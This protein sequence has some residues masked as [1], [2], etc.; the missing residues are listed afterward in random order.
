MQNQA[1]TIPNV[2]TSVSDNCPDLSQQNDEPKLQEVLLEELSQTVGSQRES[3]LGVAT[4]IATEV[5]RMCY[6]SPRI[7]TSGEVYTW[8][9][10]LGRNRLHKC[11][12]YYRLGAKQGRIELHSNLTAMIYRYVAPS[13]SQMSFQGR[14]NLIDDFL[15]E[16]YAASI[17]AFRREYELPRF[18]PRTQLELA[19]YMTFTENYAK[20]RITLP[21]GTSQQLIVLR[22]QAFVK[23]QP[24]ETSVD[25]EQAVETSKGDYDQQT[26]WSASTMQQVRSQIMTETVDPSEGMLRDRIITE[27]LNYLESQGQKDCVNYLVLKLQDLSAPDIDGFLKLTPRE[28]DYLQQRFKYHVDK[29]AR[30]SHWK[31]VHQWL[32]ADL[33]QKLGMSSQQWQE[34]LNQLSPQHRELLQLKKVNKFDEEIAKDLKWSLKQVQKQWMDLLELAWKYRNWDGQKLPGK[35]SPLH[36]VKNSPKVR[37]ISLESPLSLAVSQ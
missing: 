26:T 27:L 32:G 29:F 28:R 4:R 21:N 20:R 7:Q 30:A 18:Q 22:V 33:D 16:F 6:K 23:R 37:N 5:E 14:K 10:I 17:A 11:L 13:Q 8:Q 24:A 36:S 25:I 19:E 34:F 9:L 15:Q 31:L 2:T 35:K 3:V 1:D 12:S